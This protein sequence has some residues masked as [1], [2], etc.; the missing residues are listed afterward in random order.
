MHRLFCLLH[1]TRIFVLSS[2]R[3]LMISLFVMCFCIK[4]ELC[5][6]F[7][8][9]I[10]ALSVSQGVHSLV[11]TC[12]RKC[13]FYL[14]AELCVKFALGLRQLVL[15]Q[16]HAFYFYKSF[17]WDNTICVAL[18]TLRYLAC[19]DIYAVVSHSYSIFLAR[20][21]SQTTLSRLIK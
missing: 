7:H 4:K 19:S 3:W 20:S 10:D 6:L 5:N 13:T 16:L 17:V 15:L 21:G 11:C 12:K 8:A 2:C 1:L 18:L 14:F 9:E